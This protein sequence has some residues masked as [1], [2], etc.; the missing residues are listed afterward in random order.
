MDALIVATF[1]LGVGF[2]TGFVMR[3]REERRRRKMAKR[4]NLS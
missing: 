4:I 1:I 2:F 3:D